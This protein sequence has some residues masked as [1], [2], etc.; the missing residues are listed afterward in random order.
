MRFPYNL[1]SRPEFES[2]SLTP[3]RFNLDFRETNEQD[4]P[5]SV[6]LGDLLLKEIQYGY[7][8]IRS[9]NSGGMLLGGQFYIKGGSGYLPRKW[10]W[11]L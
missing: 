2:L 9:W 8:L 4:V 6:S 10:V 5:A 3:L 11:E 7:T 1:G